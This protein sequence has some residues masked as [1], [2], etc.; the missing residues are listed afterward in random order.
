MSKKQVLW[1]EQRQFLPQFKLRI[2][3]NW[4]VLL[5]RGGF[6]GSELDISGNIFLSMVVY[7]A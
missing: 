5:I 4:R 1:S 7:G 3:A 6:T 2:V